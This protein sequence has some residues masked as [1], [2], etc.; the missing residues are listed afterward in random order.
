MKKKI[1]HYLPNYAYVP[2]VIIFLMNQITYS[3]SKLITNHF[4]HYNISTFIDNWIPFLPIFIIVY[5]FAFIIWLIGYIVIARES[6]EVCYQIFSA[7]LIAKFFCLFFFFVFPTTIKRPEFVAS[8]IWESILLF[9]YWIDAPVN[10]FPSIHCLESWMCFRGS[11]YL[12]K[13]S[14][15]YKIFI[16]I[17][18]ILICSSTVLIKQHVFIDIVGGILIVEISLFLAKYFHTDVFFKKIEKII[19]HFK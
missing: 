16:F 10:L 17:W 4:Y 6:K 14:F 12:K 15:G 18:A 8:N 9:V 5:L 11:T 13:P 1:E 3:G 19:Q 7:E 2:L